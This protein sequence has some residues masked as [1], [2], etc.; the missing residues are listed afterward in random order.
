MARNSN[1][2]TKS[3]TKSAS[4][5]RYNRSQ[6]RGRSA[7]SSRS[8][9][10]RTRSRPLS[11]KWLRD[12]LS[13]MH[14]VEQGGEKLYQKALDELQHDELRDRLEE[15]LEETQHHVELCRDLMEAAG[16]EVDYTSPAAKAAEQKAEGLLSTEV[17][18]EA[19]RDLNNIENL[20][21]AETKDHWDWEML[22]SIAGKISDRDLKNRARKAVSEV[23]RDEREHLK[24]AQ[25]TL[26][27]L[28]MAESTEPNQESAAESMD[29]A[30]DEE[31]AQS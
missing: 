4:S 10:S 8:N 18:D 11:E 25:D 17:E 24:W 13:E 16:I 5:S 1:S 21:L 7:R 6:R 19:I 3:K 22:A 26:S 15:F 2:R 31:W 27:R 9:A 30:A 20:V 28:A 23:R 29:E 12:F 14:A